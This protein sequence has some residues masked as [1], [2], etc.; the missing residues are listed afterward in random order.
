V[1]LAEGLG[2]GNPKHINLTIA[3]GREGWK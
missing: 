1:S 2:K 3:E